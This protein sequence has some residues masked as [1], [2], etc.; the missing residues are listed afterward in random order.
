MLRRPAIKDIHYVFVGYLLVA[1]AD[2][3]VE[4]IGNYAPPRCSFYITMYRFIR[5]AECG[6]SP[7]RTA[8]N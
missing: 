5:G 6:F 4:Y 1:A 2:L 3:F 8:G 7:L